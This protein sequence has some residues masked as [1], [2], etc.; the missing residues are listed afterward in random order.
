M[1]DNDFTDSQKRALAVLTGACIVLCAYFLRG[2]F[3]L[4]VVAAVS[5]YLFAPLYN[6]LGKRFG[7]GLSAT[8]TLLA[9]LGVVVVPTAALIAVATVQISRTV[10]SV[11]GWL[12]T[13]DLSSLGQ[14]LLEIVNATLARVPF[15]HAT[16]SQESLRKGIGTAAQK[17]GEWLLTFLQGAAGSVVA[18]VAASIIFLYVFISM[19]T[20][21]ERLITL[22]HQL[23]PLGDEV[24]DIYLHRVGAMVRGTVKGQFVIALC[25]GLA[26]AA[27]VYVGGF[28]QGFFVFAILLTVL[29]VIP[30]GGGIV[31]IPLGIGMAAFGNIP[32]GVFVILWHILVVSNIDN[33]LRPILVPK[34][35]RL[36]PAL[37]ILAVFAGIAAF[38]FWGIVIGPVFMIVVVTTI[39]VYLAV[40]RGIPMEP[41]DEDKP[42]RGRLARLLTPRRG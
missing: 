40:H 19:L 26:G 24:T 10:D 15:A 1:L 22:V 33:V 11:S 36:D 9:A 2:F 38:G 27:S 3:I 7:T 41:D 39:S 37:M 16:V 20:N 30:L 14:R 21:G 8:L 31:T 34:G 5:A 12:A 29:S 32:G 13:T 17:A 28:R 35:A 18:A 4:I 42:S 25:Q 6:R 23:N